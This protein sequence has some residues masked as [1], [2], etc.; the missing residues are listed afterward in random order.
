[1][2][3]SDEEDEGGVIDEEE[4]DEE[5]DDKNLYTRLDSASSNSFKHTWNQIKAD[6]TDIS[7]LIISYNVFQNGFFDWENEGGYI[8]S[9][10]NV[11]KLVLFGVGWEEGDD[12]DEHRRFWR[13]TQQTHFLSGLRENRSIEY[14][15]F[16]S[17]F[18]MEWIT[19]LWPFFEH[20]SN[21][22]QIEFQ[23]C[24]CNSSII[25]STLTRC[26]PGSSLERVMVASNN[27]YAEMGPHIIAAL[28]GRHNLLEL[29][30][31]SN[32]ASNRFKE[33]GSAA[34]V[35][36]RDIIISTYAS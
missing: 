33:I 13:I 2:E 25:T 31:H 30:F 23:E 1:M 19:S 27:I 20:N 4:I 21:L 32:T 3:E 5:I 35:N 17:C 34:L 6:H 36:L 29:S 22:R 9:N 24:Q 26:S 16:L 7:S 10:T 28:N 11:K 12:N 15:S 18:N 14:I 8:G